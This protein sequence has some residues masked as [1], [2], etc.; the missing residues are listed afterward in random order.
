MKYI[1][2]KHILA[3]IAILIIMIPIFIFSPIIL[4]V[5]KLLL[6]LFFASKLLVKSP[7]FWVGAKKFLV[8]Q[9]ALKF[10]QEAGLF[11]IKKYTNWDRVFKYY[12][13]K[14]KQKSNRIKRQAIKASKKHKSSVLVTSFFTSTGVGIAIYSAWKY[15]WVSVLGFFFKILIKPLMLILIVGLDLLLAP[16]FMLFYDLLLNIIIFLGIKKLFKRKTAK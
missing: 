12:M 11:I 14:L 8:K 13:L 2:I 15:I 5:K 16:V 7:K 1:N 3:G 6:S 9:S 10:V 4:I